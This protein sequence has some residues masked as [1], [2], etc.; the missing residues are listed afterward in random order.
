MAPPSEP[1]REP[2]AAPGGDARVRRVLIV[3]Q[4]RLDLEGHSL[5][6]DGVE[7]ALR[8]QAFELLSYLVENPGRLVSKDELLAQLWPSKFVEEGVIKVAVSDLRRAL[9]DDAQD[10]RFIQTVHRC[11]YKLVAA[12]EQ[13][14]EDHESDDSRLR[15]VR[16][17]AAAELR[18]EIQFCTTADGVRLAY[19]TLGDGPTLIK[20]ANWL[21]HLDLD[22]HSPI[23]RHWL[24]ALSRQRRLVRYDERGTGLSDW[25]VERLDLES[26]VDDL[27]A[28]VAATAADRF[29]LL[30]ISQG[31]AVAI[32]YAVRHPERVRR[33]ILFGGY[34]RGWARRPADASAIERRQ[35]LVT[36]TR[37]GWSQEN[38]AFRQ[39]WTSLFIPDGD[40]EEMRSFNEMQRASTSAENAVRFL[41]EFGRIDIDALLPRV[42]VPT[43]VLHSQH[44]AAVPFEEGRRLA[45]GISGARFVALDSR[46]HLLLGSDAAWPR[47]LD[48]VERFLAGGGD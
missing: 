14:L 44:D 10:P 39:V 38:P 3:G 28:V 2:A 46:N 30:G 26:W 8:P 43:L 45:A 12:V 23:W 33:L 13:E 31:A 21:N 37:L 32:G 41:E 5:S 19:A 27:E 9:G 25:T 29:D 40:G 17:P 47:F 1:T 16:S 34:A 42:A 7:V 20:A 11:G 24:A 15:P 6:C 4:Y 22:R 35:A 48:E 36:T 18:Q